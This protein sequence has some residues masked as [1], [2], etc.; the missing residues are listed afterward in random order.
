[1]SNFLHDDP[2]AMAILNVFSENSRAK[3]HGQD[4]IRAYTIPNFNDHEE[5]VFENFMGIG[6]NFG[7]STFSVSLQNV[8]PYQI[9]FSGTL[10]LSSVMPLIRIS[11]QFYHLIKILKFLNTESF[12]L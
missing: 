5:D 7:K 8:P 6:E 3:N 9:L 1:M 4:K 12:V 11:V 2:R 10:D